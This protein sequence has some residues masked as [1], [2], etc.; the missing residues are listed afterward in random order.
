MDYFQERA[1]MPTVGLIGSNALVNY[2]V[3]IDYAHATV[4]FEFGRMF[5]FPDFDVIGLIL[6]PEDDGRFTILGIADL[7]GEP[8]VP[9]DVQAGDYLI[10]VDGISVS[11]STM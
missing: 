8:S 5:N 11:G 4:Y 2:R 9:G 1:G 3:G 6:R 7:D 10:A